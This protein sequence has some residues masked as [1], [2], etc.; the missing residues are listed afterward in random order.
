MLREAPLRRH[1][2]RHTGL[3]TPTES[4]T[5]VK[6]SA[7]TK[8]MCSGR[9]CVAQRYGNGT[10]LPA[11]C[12]ATPQLGTLLQNVAHEARLNLRQHE[13]RDGQ[14]EERHDSLHG[15]ARRGEHAG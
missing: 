13:G 4:G 8:P 5:T 2:S 7:E 11:L 15:A 3:K 14:H 6:I 10:L 12:A 1:T 9:L